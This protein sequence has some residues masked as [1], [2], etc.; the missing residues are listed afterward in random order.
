M[1]KN[2]LLT[3]AAFLLVVLGIYMI[4]LGTQAKILPPTV[5]GAG[6]IIIAAVFWK[7]K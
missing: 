2:S 1:S 4:Y 3:V 7:L 6:F 5:T